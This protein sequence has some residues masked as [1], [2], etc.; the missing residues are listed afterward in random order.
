MEVIYNDLNVLVFLQSKTGFWIVSECCLDR[1]SA[2]KCEC[3]S[4]CFEK[5]QNKKYIKE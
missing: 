1:K 3:Y 2:L 4:S 5:C